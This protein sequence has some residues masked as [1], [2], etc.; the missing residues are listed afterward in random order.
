MDPEES[1]EKDS[2]VERLVSMYALQSHPEGGFFT[3]TYRSPLSH[4]PPSSLPLSAS[5]CIYFLLLPSNVSKLHRIRYDEIW[6]F[7][8]GDPLVVVE[9]EGQGCRK[10]ILGQDILHGER[11]QHVVPG[12]TW[13]GCYP[14]SQEADDASLTGKKETETTRKK[15]TRKMKEGFSFVGCTVAPGFEFRDFELGEKERLL[16]DFPLAEEVIHKLT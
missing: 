8:L 9:L 16:A 1:N 14:L 11:V 4:C 6:H 2:V 10:T 12:N 5:T 15:K 13:F 3:E 7:Y